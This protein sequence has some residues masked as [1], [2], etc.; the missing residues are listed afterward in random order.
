MRR[1]ALGRL[2]PRER[3]GPGD[4]APLEIGAQVAIGQ[5]VRQTFGDGPRV[6]R[7]DQHGGVA[8]HFG[9]RRRVR[10]D[11]RR[12]AR[13]R[14]ERRQ[15]EALV[16]RREGEHRGQAIED[17]QGPV[18]HE[19]EEPH[20]A[21]Q[22]VR[23]D[24]AP[25]LGVLRDVTADDQQLERVVAVLVQVMDRLDQP[26]EVL[27]RLDVADVEHERF[28]QLEP[29]ADALDLVV[30][31]RHQEVIVDGVVDYR[32]LVG[33]DAAEAEDVALRR[34]RHRQHPPR[35]PRR[36]PHEQPGVEDGQPVGE[37]LREHQV[38]A[39]VDGHHGRTGHEN[40]Q[41][42]VRA[43]EQRHA[44]APQ[45]PGHLDLLAQRV[46]AGVRDHRPD[47]RAQVGEPGHVGGAAEHDV[48]RIVVEPHQ[49]LQQVL[50]VRADAEVVQLARIDADPHG[51]ARHGIRRLS[52][53]GTRAGAG[54]SAGG[55]WRRRPGGCR[56]TPD[57][58]PPARPDASARAGG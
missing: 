3:P 54:P 55:A 24:G 36:P 1:T 29:L 4:T 10:G 26:L 37:V 30:R 5:H 7:I 13:H 45:P 19:A 53:A 47:P 52:A 34:L 48:L 35:P 41:D 58:S 12:A 11:D 16:Q 51:S 23:V 21:V 32:H 31:R 57:S 46:V 6:G 9:Q 14:L 39:V 43:V 49:L 28:V 33:R 56:G 15:A 8:D 42:V 44:G 40:R 25:Q 2:R 22:V 27:V 17:V 18:G 38:D 50:E 20:V